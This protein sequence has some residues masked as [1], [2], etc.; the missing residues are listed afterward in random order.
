MDN[1]IIDGNNIAHMAFGIAPLQFNGQRTELI[2]VGLNM[3]SAYLNEFYPNNVKI[4]W[5]GGHDSYRTKLYPD[6]KRKKKELTDAELSEKN[7]FFSQLGALRQCLHLLGITQY[8]CKGRE[9]DDVIFTILKKMLIDNE[10]NTAVLISTDQ[11]M[12]DL[13][14]TS[15][16]LLIYSPIKKK[17]INKKS[18]EDMLGFPITYFKMYKAISGDPSD[19]LPGIYGI[20]PVGAKKIIK[21]FINEK[22]NPLHDTVSKLFVEQQEVYDQQLE[23][24]SLRE[25]PYNEIVAGKISDD[26]AVEDVFQN[27]ITIFKQYGFGI[28]NLGKFILPYDRYIRLRNKERWMDKWI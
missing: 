12:L 3:I 25:I 1:L 28:D 7:I 4:V 22:F 11:D 5:D 2:K 9:A 10:V 21:D 8:F 23:L 14:N 16:Y 19:N 27:A 24:V 13:F 6:Y 18:A 17:L 26:I 15:E 20:G